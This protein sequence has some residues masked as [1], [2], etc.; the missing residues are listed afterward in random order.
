MSEASGR[1]ERTID[2]MGSYPGAVPEI[3]VWLW[4]MEE[5]RRNL[6]AT[7]KRIERAGF[8]Q[9]FIDWRGP[10]GNDNSVGSLLYHIAGVEMGWLY[11]DVLGTG[12]PADIQELFPVDDRTEDGMLRHVADVPLADHI[13]KLATTRRRFL[14]IVG[15][16]SLEEWN[17][18]KEPAGEDYA[19]TPAWTVYHLV[20]HEAGHLYEVRRVVR[21]WL[22]AR[23]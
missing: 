2:A 1:S 14:E 21:K 12:L 20:E 23:G 4:A 6:L 5:A 7:L 8:G 15:A 19:M 9:E 10:D 18:L 17:E 11:F 22:E 13:A 16:M 3:G